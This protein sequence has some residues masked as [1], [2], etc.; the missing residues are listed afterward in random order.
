MSSNLKTYSI[1]L[2]VLVGIA[3]ILGALIRWILSIVIEQY[4]YFP[5]HAA[6]FLVNISGCFVMGFLVEWR[7]SLIESTYNYLDYITSGFIGSYT[8][9]SAVIADSFNLIIGANPFLPAILLFAHTLAGFASFRISKRV[10]RLVQQV[11]Q[12]KELNLGSED[13]SPEDRLC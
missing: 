6:T 3:G 4:L 12:N 11:T 8:T 7:L 5:S 9:F 10:L 2:W 13:S 1:T